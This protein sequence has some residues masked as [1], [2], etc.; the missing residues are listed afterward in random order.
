MPMTEAPS[1]KIVDILID[2]LKATLDA[3]DQAFL[4]AVIA[5]GFVVVHGAQGDFD[6]NVREKL[7][8]A[9]KRSSQG[10][11]AEIT[12]ETSKPQIDI[13]L[14]GFKAALYTAAIVA[15][16]CYWIFT[17]RAAL[18]VRRIA[19]LFSRLSA[20]DA[21][22]LE[23]VLLRPSLATAGP[24]GKVLSCLS[25][26]V[27]GYGSF[28]STQLPYNVVILRSTSQTL[29]EAALMLIPAIWLCGQLLALPETSLR[30]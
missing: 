4:L 22:V 8:G 7:D 15:I 11:Q 28:V 20:L 12:K 19:R 5:A 24:I 1:P 26:G 18:R 2:N 27:L 9:A 10:G 25:L 16:L 23:A 13:P 17:I 3:I 21:P 29:A 14:L 6:L 30:R